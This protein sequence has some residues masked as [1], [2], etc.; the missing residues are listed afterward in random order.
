MRWHVQPTLPHR[1]YLHVQSK[2]G[3]FV[4]TLKRAGGNGYWT[5]SAAYREKQ[6]LL[7]SG[8]YSSVK[9]AETCLLKPQP[10]S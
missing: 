9:V 2:P 10:P 8:K 4:S 6:T 7:D 1:F 3:G 5:I